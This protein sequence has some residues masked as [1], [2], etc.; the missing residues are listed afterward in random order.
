[1]LPIAVRI[2]T[3]ITIITVRTIIAIVTVVTIITIVAI[4]TIITIVTIILSYMHGVYD[5]FRSGE[6]HGFT[7][8]RGAGSCLH[9]LA[10]LPV[11]APTLWESDGA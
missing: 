11:P 3:I 7:D 6:V 2:I 10:L 9:S 5:A 1:M 4:V 8:L